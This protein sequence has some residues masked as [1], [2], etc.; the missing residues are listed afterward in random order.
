MANVAFS[1]G[2]ESLSDTNALL[3]TLLRT[4]R[5]ATRESNRDMEKVEVHIHQLI[6]ELPARK[7]GF[8][9]ERREDSGG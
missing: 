2:V 5:S 7:N 9:S 1:S 6:Y 4:R 3:R 8:R